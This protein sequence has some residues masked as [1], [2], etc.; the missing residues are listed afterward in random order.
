MTVH[1]FPPDKK[2]CQKWIDALPNANLK[3]ENI[4]QHVGVCAKHWPFDTPKI[5][6]RGKY[7]LSVPPS[8]FSSD[9]P[10]SAIPTAQD[11]SRPTSKSLNSARNPDIDQTNEFLELDRFATLTFEEFQ[12]KFF[13]LLSAKGNLASNKTQRLSMCSSA[14]LE[15]DLFL[16]SH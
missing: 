4:T 12:N 13:Q 3:A 11:K 16:I 7:R 15:M 1:C 9:L 10:K 8:C 2:E 5:N 6:C 14:Q